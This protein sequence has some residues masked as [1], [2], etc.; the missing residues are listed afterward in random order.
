MQHEHGE[1]IERLVH[2]LESDNV[3]VHINVADFMGCMHLDAYL[4]LDLSIKNYFQ[5]KLME[6][7]K[8]PFCEDEAKRKC[9]CMVEACEGATCSSKQGEEH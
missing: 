6:P 3:S 8:V 2:T 5:W 9:A 7:C 4:D 1:F